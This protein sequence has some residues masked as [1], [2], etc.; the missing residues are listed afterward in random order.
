MPPLP[1]QPP[2]GLFPHSA[3]ATPRV[4]ILAISWSWAASRCI[5]HF[6]AIRGFMRY[7]MSMSMTWPGRD[8][9]Q[10]T[11]TRVTLRK[12]HPIPA[13]SA[14]IPNAA[15]RLPP[16]RTSASRKPKTA[17]TTKYLFSIGIGDSISRAISTGVESTSD[18][19]LIIQKVRSRSLRLPEAIMPQKPP[20]LVGHHR[21]AIESCI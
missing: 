7:S 15:I 20:Y 16:V 2:S 11:L 10:R 3:V 5:F 6:P 13:T 14:R 1:A 17:A 9:V 8:R 4:A 18:K 21:S 12:A 19:F